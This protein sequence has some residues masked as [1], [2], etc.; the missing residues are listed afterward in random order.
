VIVVADASPLRYLILIDRVHVL[1]VL[2]GRVIVPPAVATELNQERTPDVVRMW[3]SAKPEWLHIQALREALSSLKDVLGP[4]EREAIALAVEVSADAVL[5][6]D[7]DGRR[8]AERRHIAV[9]GTLRVLADAADH[10]FAE[11][12]VSQLELHWRVAQTA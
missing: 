5:M 1:P 6:D 7:R 3:L 11:L 8:E 12:R 4:G 10:G 2:Y 9:L